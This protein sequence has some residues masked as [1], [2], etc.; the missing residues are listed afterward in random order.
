MRHYFTLKSFIKST[1]HHYLKKNLKVSD[2]AINSWDAGVCLPKAWT[3]LQ[4]KRLTGGALTPDQMIEDY[5]K[6]PANK[7]KFSYKSK[8]K[9]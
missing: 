6:I 9:R 7:A 5:F 1:G 4:I 2:G 8:Q 3:M